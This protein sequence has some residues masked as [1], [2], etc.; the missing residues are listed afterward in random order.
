MTE[1]TK[2]T[3]IIITSEISNPESCLDDQ[4][5]CTLRTDCCFLTTNFLVLRQI[6]DV[7]Q[8]LLQVLGSVNSEAFEGIKDRSVSGTSICKE[9]LRI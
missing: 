9:M 4:G 1:K 6:L 3:C 7:G 2:L 5:K 8:L